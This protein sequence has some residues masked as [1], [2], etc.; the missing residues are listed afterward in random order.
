[1]KIRDGHRDGATAE[2]GMQAVSEEFKAEGSRVYLPLA[3]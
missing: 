1:M 3:D 2:A